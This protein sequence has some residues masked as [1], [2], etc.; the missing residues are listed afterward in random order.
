MKILK[1]QVLFILSFIVTLI[2]ANKVYAANATISASSTTMTIGTTIN[3]TVGVQSAEVWNLELKSSGGKLD[4]KTK[5][6][7]DTPGTEVTRNVANA[8]FT[9]STP[10]TYTITLSGTIASSDDVN[11]STPQ[12]VNKQVI[13]TVTATESNPSPKPPVTN[14]SPLVLTFSNVKET[15]YAVS[16][17]NVRSSY[18]TNSSSLGKLKKGESIT[19]TGVS[20]TSVNGYVWSKVTFNGKTGYI[21]S[22]FLTK[23]KPETPA[24]VS[25]DVLP[26]PTTDKTNDATLKNLSITDVQITPKFSSNVTSYTANVEKDITQVEVL[27]VANNEKATVEITGN[28]N[29]QNGENVISVKV[30]AEDGTVNNYEIKL[31]KETIE[32]PLIAVMGI[33]ENDETIELVLANPV[34]VSEGIMEY[35]INLTEWLKAIDITG[36]LT[37]ELSLYEGIET[38]DLVVGEN[39]YTIILK[40]QVDGKE[41]ITEYRLTINNPEKV[42]PAT[43][44]NKIDY[45]LI[46]IISTSVIVT[47]IVITS[48]VVHNKKKD[49]LD[50]GKTDYSFLKSNKNKKTKGGKHF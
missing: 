39:K 10:G 13:I 6:I 15:V 3:I 46:A 41:K 11:N 9:T 49:D 48:L 36:T 21:A 23:T 50:Y 16:D 44:E 35:T 8:T 26:L 2:V 5:G 45:K 33:K 14:P 4:G 27:A 7:I 38:F 47:I 28:E 20:S 40:Q 29:L 24:S 31:T 32:K 25:P 1:K 19:R 34:I 18:S 43:N 37:D 22:N 12:S 17:V 42:I 30:T